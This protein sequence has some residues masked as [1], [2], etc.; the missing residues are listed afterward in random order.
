M[1]R[2][3]LV[4]MG[5]AILVPVIGVIA[6]EVLIPYKGVRPPVTGLNIILVM[7]AIM[8]YAISRRGL[9]SDLLTSMGGAVMPVMKDPV[10]VLNPS[11]MIEATNPAAARFT[12]YGEEETRD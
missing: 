4:L 8:A 7:A 5:L 12:G 10:F 6:V 3:R 1:E 2:D 11:G 9:L